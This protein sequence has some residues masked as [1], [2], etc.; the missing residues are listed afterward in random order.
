LWQ[1]GYNTYSLKSPRWG[2]AGHK[3]LAP[4]NFMRLTDRAAPVD[5]SM[6]RAAIFARFVFLN[7]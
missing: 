6:T 1:I 7:R 3:R 2:C 4:R 5:R